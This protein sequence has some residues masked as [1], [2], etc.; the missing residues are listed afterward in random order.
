LAGNKLK[1]SNKIEGLKR[2]SI[3]LQLYEFEVCPFCKKVREAI[4]MLDLD[5]EVY[6]CPKG[7]DRFRS[8]VLEKGGKSM[9][10]FLV[11]PNTNKEMYESDEIV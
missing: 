3:P 10:P 11:D 8:V 4:S 9:F 6:P 7:G 1:E 5:V 2:P